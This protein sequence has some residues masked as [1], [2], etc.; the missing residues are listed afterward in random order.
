MSGY[1]GGVS[2]LDRL[3]V[4]FTRERQVDPN[5]PVAEITVRLG[6]ERETAPLE[7][8]A[9]AGRVPL[10]HLVDPEHQVDVRTVLLCDRRE[11]CVLRAAR[12]SLLVENEPE[13]RGIGRPAVRELLHMAG[14]VVKRGDP[15][16]GEL[17]TK[18]ARAIE[19]EIGKGVDGVLHGGLA[20]AHYTNPPAR[21]T[22]HE[23]LVWGL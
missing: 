16:P 2:R 8:L 22:A 13:R 10:G 3:H 19:R 18:R 21:M 6:D 12:S 11:E 23:L 20:P 7:D 14:G 5:V 17:R 1:P 9:H 4:R 15:A